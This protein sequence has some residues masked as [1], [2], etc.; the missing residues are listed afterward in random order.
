M[1]K[2]EEVV[3]GVMLAIVVAVPVA[4]AP[5][6]RTFGL[7]G[8]TGMRSGERASGRERQFIMRGPSTGGTS[9]R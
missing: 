2:P 9:D 4:P 8:G 3:R 5:R 6:P 7:G 1:S